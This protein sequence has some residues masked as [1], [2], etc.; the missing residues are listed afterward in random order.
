M[1]KKIVIAAA[2]AFLALSTVG[3]ASTAL[4]TNALAATPEMVKCYGIVKKG[5]NDCATAS[6]SC[7]AS[8]TKDSQPDAFLFVPK[9]LCEKIVGGNLNP[10]KEQK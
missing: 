4:M 9:G 5:M 6:A 2:K 7:A 1:D 3:I 10:P 8:A